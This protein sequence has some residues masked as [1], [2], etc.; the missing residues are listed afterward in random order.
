MCNNFHHPNCCKQRTLN[1]SHS[2]SN[3]RE[4]GSRKDTSDK[5]ICELALGITKYLE[6]PK[7]REWPGRQLREHNEVTEHSLIPGT[8]GN[9]I[10]DC[11]T[12]RKTAPP[13]ICPTS[14]YCP[15]IAHSKLA[16]WGETDE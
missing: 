2:V 4:A 9:K 14:N 8:R 10:P 13:F 7:Q 15:R 16:A 3:H 1:W 11:R 12:G 5:A 6:V